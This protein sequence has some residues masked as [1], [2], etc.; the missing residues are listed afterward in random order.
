MR[1]HRVELPGIGTGFRFRT[2]TGLWIGVIH[3]RDGRRHLLIYDTDDP[4]TVR[5]SVPLQPVEAHELAE[6]LAPHH[7]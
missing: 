6:V 2:G 5:S 4:D 1:L 3:H 7:Q